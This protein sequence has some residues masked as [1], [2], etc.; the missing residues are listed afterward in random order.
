MAR[1]RNRRCS[2]NI[3]MLSV[4]VVELHVTVNYA[5]TQIVAEEGVNGKYISPST[6]KNT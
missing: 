5:R 3:T 1:S 2:E 6:I 4:C